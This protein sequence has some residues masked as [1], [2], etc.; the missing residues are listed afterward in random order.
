MV[1]YPFGRYPF[2]AYNET[3]DRY[4]TKTNLTTQGVGIMYK[5]DFNKWS[6][7]YFWTKWRLRNKRKR[8]EAEKVKTQQTDSITDK[9]AMVRL[10]AI[11]SKCF[12][13][14]SSNTFLK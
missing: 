4:Y 3:N 13:V 12:C 5:K 1:D 10:S 9:T 6:D 11:F 2:E 8:E 7:L 14:R